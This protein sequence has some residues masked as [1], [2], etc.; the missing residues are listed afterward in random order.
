MW[1]ALNDPDVLARCIPG[2][3]NLARTSDDVFEAKVRAKV[4]PVSAS[5]A[6][7]VRLSEI[8]PPFSYVISG[9][10]KGG[11]AGFAKGSAKV[12]LEEEGEETVLSYA[13]NASIGGKL[14]QLGARLISG[15]VEKYANGFFGTLSGILDETPVQTTFTPEVD[16]PETPIPLP[17]PPSGVRWQRVL[18]AVLVGVLIALGAWTLF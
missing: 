6:G 16:A 7:T 10:G 2:C 18:V 3:E 4:G 1:E 5:F 14:A 8:V 15:T 17:M 11:A 9:E 12:S 13:I